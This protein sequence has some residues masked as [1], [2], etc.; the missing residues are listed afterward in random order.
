[1]AATEMMWTK[2]RVTPSSNMLIFGDFNVDSFGGLNK[3]LKLCSLELIGVVWNDSPNQL[4]HQSDPPAPTKKFPKFLVI[5]KKKSLF[6]V[7]SKKK[8]PPGK[9]PIF[10][11][12]RPFRWFYGGAQDLTP[13][14]HPSD[15]SPSHCSYIKTGKVTEATEVCDQ[16][17]PGW[18]RWKVA[19]CIAIIGIPFRTKTTKKGICAIYFDL[20]VPGFP[21]WPLFWRDPTPQNKANL[22]IKTRGPIWVPGSHYRDPGPWHQAVYP[23]SPIKIPT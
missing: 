7:R 12:S 23:R 6:L 8:S 21:K 14:T 1:M 11:F 15:P 5:P 3:S 13:A 19:V 22:P 2:G 20:K 9:P 4:T 17:I 18:V 10:L 16:L